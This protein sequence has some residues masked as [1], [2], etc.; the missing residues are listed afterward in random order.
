MPTVH[1]SQYDIGRQFQVYLRDGSKPYYLVSG[2]SLISKVRKPNGDVI[3][4]NIIGNVGD[5]YVI[6]TTSEG[7]CDI[8]GKN[9]CELKLENGNKKIGTLNFFMN[10]EEA[11]ADAD[12][13]PINDFVLFDNGKWN[14]LPNYDITLSETGAE[15]LQIIDGKLYFTGATGFTMY[16]KDGKPFRIDVC[17][18]NLEDEYFY[19]Q[20]G[21]CAKGADAKVV[22]NTGNYRYNYHVFNSGYFFDNGVVSQGISDSYSEEQAIFFSGADFC[23]KRICVFPIINAYTIRDFLD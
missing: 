21:R 12:P 20:T 2:D 17:I 14:D 9:I 13:L 4:E 8:I 23:I 11:I 15:D 10:V 19:I 1:T 16:S 5:D 7:M 18:E 22:L 6:I 3:L